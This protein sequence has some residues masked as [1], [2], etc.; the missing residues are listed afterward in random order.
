MHSA[1]RTFTTNGITLH[2]V[3]FP[4]A[5]PPIILMPGLT[6]NAASFD[7]LAAR[8]SPARRVLALDLRGRGRS[9]Q[10]ATGYTMADHAAD[11]LGVLDALG[12]DRAIVGGHSFGGL[13][14]IYL[15]AHHPDRVAKA[16]V[17][18]AGELHPQVF[19]L[20]QPSV[21]RLGQL[22]PSWD[23]YI[24]AVKAQPIFGGWWDPAIERYYRADLR[25]LEDGQVTP[26]SRPETIAAASAGVQAERWGDLMAA[27]RQPVLLVN[28]PGA[29]GPPGAPAVQPEEAGRRTA[30]LMADCRYVKVP[31]NH[32]TMLYGAGAEAIAAAILAFVRD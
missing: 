25:T 10:P 32:M 21:Q 18:D 14:T 28:A 24:A 13:L 12:I 8:L 9:D 11:I 1:D 29:Y 23:E 19:A 16:I 22:Y 7:A 6:A 17:L 27:V 5:E 20:I 30:A 3:E 26:R 2:G 15:A 31:G 4:G